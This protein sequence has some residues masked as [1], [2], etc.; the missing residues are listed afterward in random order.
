VPVVTA[1]DSVALSRRRGFDLAVAVW[2]ASATFAI[3]ILAAIIAA[4]LLQSSGHR[5]VASKI[6]EY[7]SYLCHQIPE[8]SFHLAG[9]QFAVC[10]RWVRFFG[11]GK[12]THSL[13]MTSQSKHIRFV[14][15]I[16]D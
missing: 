5:T 2:A 16:H 14:D 7:F 4:P 12:R 15:S 9:E 1:N 11:S 10:S 6:Y 8:R 13:V 3:A